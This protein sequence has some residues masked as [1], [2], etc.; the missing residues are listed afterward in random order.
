M[1]PPAPDV[2]LDKEGSVVVVGAGLGGLRSAEM[3]RLHGHRGPIALVGDEPHPPYDRPPLTKQFLAGTWDEARISLVKDDRLG[4]LGI[5]LVTGA[6][7][8]LDVAGRAVT[9]ADGRRLAGDAVVLATGASPRWLPGTEG[10]RGVHVIRTLEQSRAVRAELDATGGDGSVVVIGAGFI[11][12][13]VASTAA[14]RGLTVTLLE[15]LE[16]PLSP[17]VGDEVGTWLTEL[18]RR[19]GVEVRAGVEI[20]SVTPRTETER[21]TVELATGERLEADLVVVGIGVRPATGWLDDAGLSLDDGVVTD[22]AL[23]AAD[24]V[25]AVGDLARFTWHHGGQTEQVRI[26]H[27]EVTAQLATHAAHA[28][29]AGRRD[30]LPIAI[31]PYFWSDQHGRKIQ[32]LGR[33]SGSDDATRVAGSLDEARFTFLY[34]R[35]GRV[36]GVLGVGSPRHVMISRTHVDEGAPIAEALALFA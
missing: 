6:A 1:P 4:D 16:I 34:H 3:L 33:P 28:L 7:A 36:T 2:P 20:T 12:S 32:M 23:F 24:G 19:A 15:A 29:L 18:H 17:I 26:E 35:G 10:A 14:A 8:S 13:E 30:A 21:P 27:W 5:E 22:A 25:V 9:L 11:G 31:V